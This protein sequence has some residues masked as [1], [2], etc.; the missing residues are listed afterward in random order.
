MCKVTFGQWNKFWHGSYHQFSQIENVK[1][2]IVF[3]A[4][5]IF[6]EKPSLVYLNSVFF[7]VISFSFSS[8]S[9]SFS[10]FYESVVELLF[11]LL[12]CYFGMT[13]ASHFSQCIRSYSSPIEKALASNQI[14][15]RCELYPFTEIIRSVYVDSFC[16]FFLS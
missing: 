3:I 2:T 11:L 5:G 14:K 15:T 10:L 1:K 9:S 8:S 7:I 12:F 6:I 4:S 16:S 13:R